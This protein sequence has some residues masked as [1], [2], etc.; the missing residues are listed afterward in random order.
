MRAVKS[1]LTQHDENSVIK[2]SWSSV[3]HVQASEQIV[4]L[5]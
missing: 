4:K 3:Q 2:S 5:D 1:E